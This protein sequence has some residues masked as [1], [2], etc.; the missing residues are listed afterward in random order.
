VSGEKVFLLQDERVATGRIFGGPAV[1][2]ERGCFL[3]YYVIKM[4]KGN[5]NFFWMGIPEH[6]F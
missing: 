6:L 2:P 1:Q 4:R 3:H 5:I